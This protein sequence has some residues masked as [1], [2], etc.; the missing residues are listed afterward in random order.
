VFQQGLSLSQQQTSHRSQFT[1]LMSKLT[2]KGLAF[3]GAMS[4]SST[5]ASL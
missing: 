2:R 1:T 3:G 5:A 4:D